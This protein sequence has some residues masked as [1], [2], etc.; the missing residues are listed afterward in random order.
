MPTTLANSERER[1]AHAAGPTVAMALA[2]SSWSPP[3]PSAAPWARLAALAE[4]PGAAMAVSG[5][6]PSPVQVGRASGSAPATVDVVGDEHL[7]AAPHVQTPPRTDA[8]IAIAINMSRA[9]AGDA[10]LMTLPRIHATRRST[11][12]TRRVA[13]RSRYG[14]AADRRDCQGA[15]YDWSTFP[16][17]IGARDAARVVKRV[18]AMPAIRPTIPSHVMESQEESPTWPGPSL[19]PGPTRRHRRALTIGPHKFRLTRFIPRAH[20]PGRASAKQAQRTTKSN[21]ELWRV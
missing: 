2:G 5:S 7:T 9:A 10:S 19:R 8:A 1:L 15:R 16:G 3:A 14:I 18:L 11:W 20:G 17:T 4:L 12:R 21:N 6:I 13:H